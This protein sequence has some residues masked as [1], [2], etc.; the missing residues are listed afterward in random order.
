M[1]DLS[2]DSK[3]LKDKSASTDGPRKP[4][5]A[6]ALEDVFSTDHPTR[7]AEKFVGF[8]RALTNAHWVSLS[9]QDDESGTSVIAGNPPEN[10][11]E[12]VTA[13]I[14]DGLN[15]GEFEQAQV[16][17]VSS[18]LLVRVAMPTGRPAILALGV[19]AS[20]T[21]Q[22]ALAHERATFL[23]ALSFSRNLP[24]DRTERDG[25][26]TDIQAI[27]RGEVSDVS[28]IVDLLAKHTGASYAAA[29]FSRDGNIG[30][31]KISGQD[32]AA[33]RAS[34]PEKIKK[35]MATTASQRL[36]GQDRSYAA[37]PHQS[38]GLVIHLENPSR[39]RTALPLLSA[40]YS[41]SQRKRK[42]QWFTTG[43]LVRIGSAALVLVGL[44]LIPLPDG[45]ELPAIVEAQ[46]SRVITAPATATLSTINVRDGDRVV[47]GETSLFELD[48]NDIEIEL[49]GIRAERAKAMLEREASRASRNAAALRNAELEV[50]R[51]DARVA[52]LD[53]RLASTVVVAPI[54]GTIIAPD[55][56]QSEGTTVRQG[57]ELLTIADPSAMRLKLSIPES[58]I[59]KL[60][61]GSEGIFRP[62]F[63]PTIRL[64][65]KITLVS[66]AGLG[67]DT[68]K[69]YLGRA[70]FLNE[71]DTVRP[72]LNGVLS[73]QRETRPLGQIV[74]RELRDHFLLNFWF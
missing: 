54:S 26:I 74:Y 5:L 59:G 69:M 63:D 39:N 62:D 68:Q 33:K 20:N 3:D 72:G 12:N 70:E 44:A 71:P 38:E 28:R 48:N 2:P 41:L 22:S 67:E 15:A 42:R 14:T 73:V 23:G 57:E 50:Q 7:F 58:Q 47:A 18:T 6:D 53:A 65:S 37:A 46:E 49:I 61:D 9:V 16:T 21:V 25:L 64:E 13:A 32:G 8:A 34:L 24:S 36:I 27:A 29:A 30:G 17:T 11:P 10:L 43:R 4:T 1:T 56:G 19:S 35:E 31:L 66:P 45:V 52:L 40:V 55:L 51:L 60:G